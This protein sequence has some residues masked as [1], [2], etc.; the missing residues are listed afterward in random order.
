MRLEQVLFVIHGIGE[1]ADA[2][3]GRSDA[4]VWSREVVD[5]LREACADYPQI[6]RDALTI[7]PILYDDVFSTYQRTWQKLAEQLGDTPLGRATEWLAKADE[8]GFVWG[9]IADI[10]LYKGLPAVRTQVITEVAA[11]I[12]RTIAERGPSAR[13]SILAHSLGTAVAHDVVHKLATVPIDGNSALMPPAFR[14][15]NFFALANVSRL[16]AA[17]DPHFYDETRVR[18]FDCGL[19]ESEC[20]VSH[21][22]SFRHVADPIPSVVRFSRP[23]WSKEHFHR[24]DLR[25]FRDLNVHAFNHYL[26]SPRVIDRVLYR[27]YGPAAVPPDLMR[28]RIDAFTDFQGVDADEVKRAVSEVAIL[29]DKV[30]FQAHGQFDLDFVAL[31]KVVPL[32]LRALKS[33]VV[34]G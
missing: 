5:L 3:V 18:P 10:A 23:T 34:R 19:P 17:D 7:V 30:S 9:S 33:A 13:Y 4:R 27:L 22:V 20:A 6:G 25:H 16:V 2:V 14:F 26:A 29:L 8:P 28:R 21:Y 24:V 15:D 31:L 1:H 11:T 32:A 12:A